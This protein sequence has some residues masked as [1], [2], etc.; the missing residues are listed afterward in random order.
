MH[1]RTNRLKLPIGGVDTF[2]DVLDSGKK[3]GTQEIERNQENMGN[4][5]VSTY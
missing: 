4:M 2:I 5:P 3:L 1:H